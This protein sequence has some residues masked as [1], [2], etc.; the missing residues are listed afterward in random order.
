MEHNHLFH[1]GLSGGSALIQDRLHRGLNVFPHPE[2][3][4]TGVDHPEPAGL[5]MRQ[6]EV[7]LPHPLMENQGFVLKAAFPL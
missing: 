7:A 3:V 1:G 4:L 6:G 5:L 2:F